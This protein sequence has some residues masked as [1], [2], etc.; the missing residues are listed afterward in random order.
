VWATVVSREWWEDIPVA[1]EGA[2]TKSD[3]VRA[4]KIGVKKLK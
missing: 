2:S 4:L 3:A 1:V